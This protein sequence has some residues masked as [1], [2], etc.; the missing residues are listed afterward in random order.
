VISIIVLYSDS[1]RNSNVTDMNR[2]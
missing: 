2:A 1:L